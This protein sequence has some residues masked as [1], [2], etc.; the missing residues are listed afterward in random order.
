M[1]GARLPARPRGAD[2]RAAGRHAAA[3]RASP[4][5]APAPTP[6]CGACSSRA[7]TPTGRCTPR[8]PGW[9]PATARWPWRSPTAPCSGAPRSTT[10]LDQLSTPARRRARPAGAGRAA[11]GADAAAVPRRRSPST[12]PSTR[13]SSWPS[14]P[15]AG[16]A[17]LVNAVL[18]RAAREGRAILAALDDDTPAGGRRRCTRC[19][20]GWPSCGGRARGRAGAGAAARQSTEPAESALRVNTLVGSTARGRARELGREPHP[21][22][23]LCRR[24]SSSTGRLTPTAR[25]CGPGARSC[26]SRGLDA[27]RAGAGARSPASGCSTCAPPPGAKT[28]HLAALMG[29]DGRDRSPSSAIRAAPRRCGEPWPGCSVTCATVEVADAAER[30]ALPGR[31]TTACWSTRRAAASARCSPAPT[32]AG[33][34][35][36]ERIAELARLQA[37]D[38]RRRRARATAPGGTLV[39][40]VCTISRAESEEVVERFLADHPEFALDPPAGCGARAATGSCCRTATAPTGS[41]SPGCAGVG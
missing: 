10:S 9:T 20:R 13:A 12:P 27:R 5:R 6:S 25:R 35:S 15:A 24:D 41:S 1:A 11:P 3:P 37:P 8:P 29:D 28:T 2:G 39:Y 16:G 21:A 30:P 18:R 36:P 40:S 23:G 26:P 4:R 14:A 31:P 33:A 17:G 7:P 22:P 32:C 34:T 38:P 19:R